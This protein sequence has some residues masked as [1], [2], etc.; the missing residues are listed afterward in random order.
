EM[1]NVGWLPCRLVPFDASS[2]G[3]SVGPAG[4]K[5]TSAAWSPDGRWMYFSSD[6]GGAFH[7]WRQ[8]FPDGKPEQITFG[9]TEEEGLAVAPDGR[10]LIASVGTQQST[11]WIHDGNGERQLSSEGSAVVAG[12]VAFYA[13]FS[14]D[15]RKLYYLRQGVSRAFVSGELWVA[16]LESGRNERVLPG[17]LMT[18]YDISP[19]D[20]WVAFTALDAQGR[21]Q[22]WRA[23][24]DLRYPPQEVPSS[25]AKY[26]IFAPSGELFF[27]DSEGNQ[28]FIYR[29]KKDSTEREKVVSD[30]IIFLAG[31]SPDGKWVLAHVEVPGEQTG[32]PLVAF[33]LA[34]GPRMRI[35]D[36][37]IVRWS[38]DGAFLYISSRLMGREGET[39]VLR[40]QPGKP[41]PALPPGGLQSRRDLARL[42]VAQVI[43]RSEITPGPHPS[44]YAFTQKSVHRN[45]YRIPLP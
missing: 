23:P 20:K 4:A 18:N 45:L 38:R 44:V 19:D 13:Y 27:Q 8:R 10:S 28:N 34:G 17:F 21:S 41:F 12:W 3:A 33:P 22:L 26:P 6:A 24:L 40:V 37:C 5:C 14:L 25:V 43:E 29:P 16:D 31:A 2:S 30:P 36:D 1:D 39:F 7:V 9:P 42:P 15:G 11:L 35:C 32:I